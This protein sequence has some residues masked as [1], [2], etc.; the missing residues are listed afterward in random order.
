MLF[1]LDQYIRIKTADPA[2]YQEGKVV[3]TGGG[4]T[5]VRFIGRFNHVDS[6]FYSEKAFMKCFSDEELI[7]EMVK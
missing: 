3:A 2:V 5:T 1:Y 7:K 4:N 6:V